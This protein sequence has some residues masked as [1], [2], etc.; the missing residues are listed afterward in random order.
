M[1]RE[2]DCARPVTPAS[3][4]KI[5]LAVIGYDAG[6]LT[7]ATAPTWPFRPGYPAWI[8]SWRQPH[9]PTT[10][11]RESVLWYSQEITR[12]LGAARFARAVKALD[13]GNADVSGDSGAGNGLTRAWLS[14]SLKISADEQVAFLTRL[15]AGTLPVAPAA[16]ALAVRLLE[17]DARPQGWRVF[18]KT[19]TG[20]MKGGPTYGW[21]V[22]W[23]ER[24]GRRLVF[25]RLVEGGDWRATR[26]GVVARDGILAELPPPP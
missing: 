2:G 6:I 7:S 1:R 21:F 12:R 22:G 26:P 24:D 15:A 4:F 20:P 11:M 5:A 9:S 10:W 14:S 3:T 25:A 18:G 19:G 13:Y 8:A 23:A 16:Q 17:Q